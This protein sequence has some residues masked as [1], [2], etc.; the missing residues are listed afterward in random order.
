MANI[1]LKSTSTKSNVHLLCHGIE[2]ELDCN[3]SIYI[4]LVPYEGKSDRMTF[5]G[6]TTS[7]LLLH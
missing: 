4:S 5:S 3:K 7:L 2:D 1:S 6:K